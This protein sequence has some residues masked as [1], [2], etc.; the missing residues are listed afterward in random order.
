M[1]PE[2]ASK[3]DL[4]AER[5]KTTSL[6]AVTQFEKTLSLLTQRDIERIDFQQL[7][8]LSQN[9]DNSELLDYIQEITDSP[10]SFNNVTQN[11]NESVAELNKNLPF[12][13]SFRFDEVPHISIIRIHEDVSL[14]SKDIY[15][16]HATTSINPRIAF[17][18]QR[19]SNK[20]G[21]HSS[22]ITL[23]NIILFFRNMIHTCYQS[24]ARNIQ[25]HASHLFEIGPELILV[26]LPSDLVSLE[27]LFLK[28]TMKTPDEWI[29]ENTIDGILTEQGLVNAKNFNFRSFQQ[30]MLTEMAQTATSNIRFNLLH[31]F[32]ACHLM[33]ELFSATYPPPGHIILCYQAALMPMLHLDFDNGI[34]LSASQRTSASNRLSPNIVHAMGPTWHGEY[35]ISLSACGQAFVSKIETARSF[36]EVYIGDSFPEDHSVQN[37]KEKSEEIENCLLSLVSPSGPSCSAEDCEEWLQG[38]DEFLKQAMIP[39]NQ[40]LSAIPWF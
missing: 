15:L 12:I 11:I 2:Q 17:L 34:H 36:F 3:I 29:E 6:T 19:S 18:V 27:E 32:T 22:V 31:T 8:Q 23:S 25:M 4:F 21:F 35:I 40:P 38:V 16:I 9:K 7:Y 28:S 39:E 26:Y 14:L 24:R 37:I 10:N 30:F 1:T 33:R 20:S 5:Q 13:F